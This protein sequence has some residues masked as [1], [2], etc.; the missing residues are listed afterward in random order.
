MIR[1]LSDIPAV[2]SYLARVGAEARAMRTAAV[3]EREGRYWRDVATIKIER[4]GRVA[5]NTAEGE[6]AASFEPTDGE[7]HAIA[8]EATAA[9]WPE[10]I[11]P[12]GHPR[13]LPDM[14]KAAEP[15]DLF[16]FRDAEGHIAMLQ[17]RVAQPGG[18]KSYLPF[19]CWSDDVWRQLEPEGLLPLW[20]I[21]QLRNYATAFIHEG[22]K[23]AR[24]VRWLAE[25]AE[26]RGAAT[27]DAMKALAA[28]PWGG[29]LSH[30]AHLGWIGGALSPHRTDWSMLPRPGSSAWSL[31]LTTTRRDMPL[32]PRSR[33]HSPP[34]RSRLR[35]SGS[36]VGSLTAST[37]QT[38]FPKDFSYEH[39]R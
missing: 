35:R 22:A 30:S 9:L 11:R 34:T 20:G 26:P 31:S 38:R 2:R 32:C 37:W 8:I 1:D 29:A 13:N 3:R 14:V 6:D 12:L 5:V 16:E 18:G 25:A 28:H 33:G 19:T 7:R 36:T 4:D 15:E 21:D 39:W 23:A 17:L 27:R 24:A 10:N